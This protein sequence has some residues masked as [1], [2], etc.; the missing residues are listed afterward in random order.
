MTTFKDDWRDRAIADAFAMF[1]LN[2][3][4]VIEQIKDG[5][6]RVLAIVCFDW[7]MLFTPVSK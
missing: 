1:A 7:F 6:L 2:S 5:R 3:D 4:G